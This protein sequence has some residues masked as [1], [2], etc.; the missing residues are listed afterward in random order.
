M[1]VLSACVEL[2]K[3]FII[4]GNSPG[5]CDTKNLVCPVA[6]WPCAGGAQTSAQ[7]HELS[8]LRK[9]LRGTGAFDAPALSGRAGTRQPHS[10][11]FLGFPHKCHP[12]GEIVPLEGAVGVSRGQEGATA[13]TA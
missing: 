3:I 8:V 9:W 1:L 5:N 11:A 6:S 7:S 4:F 13:G 12:L 10:T 2:E